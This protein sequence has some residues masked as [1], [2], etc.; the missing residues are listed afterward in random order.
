MSE[1]KF[2]WVDVKTDIKNR[3]TGSGMTFTGKYVKEGEM[4]DERSEKK[5]ADRPLSDFYR[6]Q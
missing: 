4:E 3:T 2:I 5:K 1:E 6:L